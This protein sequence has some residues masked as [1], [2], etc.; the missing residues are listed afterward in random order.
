M[1]ALQENNFS[2][3]VLLQKNL[4]SKKICHF[5]PDVITL[6]F[7]VLFYGERKCFL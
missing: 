1:P 7:K 3:S 4:L 2:C 5:K 6:Y